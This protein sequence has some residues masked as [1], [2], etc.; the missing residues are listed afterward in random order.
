VR[1]RTPPFPSLPGWR[2]RC[3]PLLAG[4]ALTLAGVAATAADPLNDRLGAHC[5]GMP[6]AEEALRRLNAERARGAICRGNAAP[7]AAAPLRW[8]DT[9]AAAA[10][11]QS[12]DMA[13]VSRMGHYDTRNRGLAERLTAVGYRYSTAV[14][15]VAFGY[16]SLDGVVAAW[17]ASEGHC[18][19][20]MN[21]TVLELGLACSDGTTPGQD[22]YW[23]LVLGAP[24]RSR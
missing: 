2:A 18:S 19:N 23:T 1:N 11:A 20:M 17:L 22:R 3:L 14:E 10:A 21:P 5:R 4:C 9:L 7:G 15:N 6:S 12:D 13:S 24:P 8:N 16:P